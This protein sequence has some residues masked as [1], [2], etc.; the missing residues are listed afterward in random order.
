L[1]LTE[2]FSDLNSQIVSKLFNNYFV[3]VADNLAKK[4]PKPNTKYQDYLKI[5]M[6]IAYTSMKPP[7]MKLKKSSVN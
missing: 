1:I 7:L 2:N 6:N 3:N 4:I 5:L